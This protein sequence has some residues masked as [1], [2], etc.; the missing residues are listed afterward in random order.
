MVCSYLN[1][2]FLDLE[3]CENISEK[4][5]KQLNPNSD[6]DTSDSNDDTSDS[7]NDTS[8]FD[9]NINSQSEDPPP[10]IPTFTD[11]LDKNRFISDLI[12]ATHHSWQE[13]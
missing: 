2:K 1:L 12:R 6:D 11:I 4:L 13:L 7:D 5:V 9:S 10:L 8:D 3:G